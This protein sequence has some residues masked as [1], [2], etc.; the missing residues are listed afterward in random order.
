MRQCA[1][2][3]GYVRT[4][5]C[6]RGS[7]RHLRRRLSRARGRSEARDGCRSVPK[8]GMRLISGLGSC[9]FTLVYECSKN[10]RITAISC[11]FFEGCGDRSKWRVRSVS[12][13]RIIEC[14]QM[15]AFFDDSKASW[16]W[17]HQ[18]CHDKSRVLFTMLWPLLLRRWKRDS[19]C[20]RRVVA[21]Q[22]RRSVAWQ[23]VVAGMP[24]RG[25][26]GDNGQGSGDTLPTRGG[27]RGSFP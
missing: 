6:A 17:C 7:R 18:D 8:V 14:G 10:T 3:C 24:L 9:S 22:G 25:V 26:K 15:E 13:M 19:R 27:W 20:R 16:Q 5:V 2:W 4:R 21:V 12:R 23:T 11:H 1:A